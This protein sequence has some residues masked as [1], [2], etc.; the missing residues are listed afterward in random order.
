MNQVGEAPHGLQK[1]TGGEFEDAFHKGWSKVWIVES[2][3]TPIERDCNAKKRQDEMN[4]GDC[5]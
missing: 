3:N 1:N 4:R 5:G 2:R